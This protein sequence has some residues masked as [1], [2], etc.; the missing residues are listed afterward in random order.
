MRKQFALFAFVIFI[1]VLFHAPIVKAQEDLYDSPNYFSADFPAERMPDDSIVIENN[2]A[3]T[4]SVRTEIDVWERE[5]GTAVTDG[6]YVG[7]IFESSLFEIDYKPYRDNTTF[8]FSGWTTQERELSNQSY[9]VWFTA[10]HRVDFTRTIQTPERRSVLTITTNV[11]FTN[12]M[13]MSGATEFWVRLPIHPDCVDFNEIQPTVAFFQATSIDYTKLWT[14]ND[15][16][17]VYDPWELK[18]AFYPN[19]TVHMIPQMPGS[20]R[21]DLGGQMALSSMYNG[22]TPNLLARVSSDYVT[23][24]SI[25]AHVYGTVEPNTQYLVVAMCMLKSKPRIYITEDDLCSNERS[26][27]IKL[28]DLD[29]TSQIFS[30]ADWGIDTASR[31]LVK[32][33][34]TPYTQSIGSPY[35]FQRTAPQSPTTAYVNTTF[36]APIDPSFS[37][38]FKSGRGDYGMFG[39]KVHFDPTDS[40]V[41]YKEMEP[42]FIDR[43]PSVMI[44]FISNMP[45][46]VNLTVC[47]LNSSYDTTGPSDVLYN[48]FEPHLVYDDKWSR[49]GYPAS[50]DKSGWL[51][52][53]W[54]QAPYNM[55]YTDYILFTVP[56][57]V[58][59]NQI[60][61]PFVIK[62][63]VTFAEAA[64]VTFMFSTF[65]TGDGD[66]WILDTGPVP[67]DST[68]AYGLLSG[69]PTYQQAPYLYM[70]QNAFYVYR[71]V[72]NTNIITEYYPY[73]DSENVLE[74]GGNAVYL[75]E[76]KLSPQD[77][78]DNTIFQYRLFSSVQFTEGLWHELVTSSDGYQYATHFFQRRVAIGVIDLWV[79]T[80]NNQS[81]H[82]QPWYSD[83]LNKWNLAYQSLT[84]WDILNAIKYG[85]EG[86]ISFLWNGL[87]AFIGVIV[88]F[89]KK[90]WE[91][92]KGIGKFI[93]SVLTSFIGDILSIIGDLANSFERILEVS[94]YIIAILIF[95]WVVAWGGKMLYLTRLYA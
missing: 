44:P 57:K 17:I 4:S 8:E 54:W 1:G 2:I 91:G 36:E 38:I 65:N 34:T 85:V 9:G 73:K 86:A 30:W 76:Y 56:W 75:N 33:E 6:S 53:W 94:L 82:Q 70:Q 55:T 43:Y 31:N 95:M 72:M 39:Q 10:P 50:S 46:I 29:F 80:T 26:T 3:N 60:S 52:P 83:A 15:Y 14:A 27:H 74:Y 41:F 21:H 63:M 67:V 28:T 48:K 7:P 25:Y 45:I 42:L 58:S 71:D 47:L 62:V 13:I 79:D 11:T 84:K 51:K 20:I 81:V 12:R 40:F 32:A 69:P 5:L 37:F 18:T 64:D 89:F 77:M 23:D 88:G 90:V 68:N 22:N 66:S 92:L 61:T 78:N 49:F 16:T 93:Y 19:G 87:K 59:S 24:D 35:P